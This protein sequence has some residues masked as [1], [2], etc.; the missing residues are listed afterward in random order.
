MAIHSF[1]I[2]AIIILIVTD[3]TGGGDEFKDIGFADEFLNMMGDVSI[4]RNI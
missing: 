3:L 4:N 2:K 1:E